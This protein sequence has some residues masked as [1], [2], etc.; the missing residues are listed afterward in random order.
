MT[1]RQYL[2]VALSDKGDVSSKRLVTLLIAGHFIL[3]SFVTLFFTFY[4]IIQTPKGR[5]DINLIGLLKDILAY[6]FYIILSGLSFIG[7]ENVTSIIISKYKQDLGKIV[8]TAQNQ[9]ITSAPLLQNAE[10]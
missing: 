7:A 1:W 9:S 5:V 3:A 4:M 10:E 6:D 2:N 8:Q